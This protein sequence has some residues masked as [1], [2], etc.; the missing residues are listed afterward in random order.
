MNTI[1]Q[2]V[3]KLIEAVV[4]DDDGKLV[5]PE[6]VSEELSYA[7]KAEI[8]RRDTQAAYTK[9]QQALKALQVEKQ[10]LAKSWEADAVANLS[11]TEQAALDELKSQDPDAWRVKISEMEE[12]KRTEFKAKCETITADAQSSTELERRQ[13]QLE[14]YNLDHP[15]EKLTDEVIAN[16]IPPR[17]TKKLQNGDIQ[18]SQFLEEVAQY[19]A[20]G[21]TLAET[22]KP[23][24]TKSIA[25][26]RGAS[27]PSEQQQNTTEY[28]EEIF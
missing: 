2:E 10:K 19:L 6:G 12:A 25:T 22:A 4:K 9:G 8:R 1:E 16:D 20:K 23:P 27:Q 28:N 11:A 26:A 18:F 14:Q 7:A 24:E 17:I 21:K 3:N 15:T 13:L 5:M